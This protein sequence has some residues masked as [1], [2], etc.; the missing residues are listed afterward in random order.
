[1]PPKLNW[2]G[3]PLNHQRRTQAMKARDGTMNVMS[4]STKSAHEVRQRCQEEGSTTG[5]MKKNATHH[6]G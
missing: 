4:A 1:M 2:K 6:T 5:R 3:T